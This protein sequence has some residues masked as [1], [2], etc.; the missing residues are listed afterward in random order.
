MHNVVRNTSDNPAWFLLV[1]RDRWGLCQLLAPVPP[2]N[3]Y[4]YKLGH[5]TSTT[6]SSC[7]TWIS[8]HHQVRHADKKMQSSTQGRQWRHSTPYSC[9]EW[10]IW[11]CDVFCLRVELWPQRSGVSGVYRTPLHDV[12][13]RGHLYS[14]FLNIVRYLTN[15]GKCNPASL[16]DQ[17]TSYSTTSSLRKWTST[18]SKIIFDWGTTLQLPLLWRGLWHSITLG[19][20]GRSTL[21]CEHKNLK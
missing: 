2:H 7:Y 12:S 16:D 8:K 6:P 11:D 4:Y 20:T 3:S 14:W 5:P 17:Q 18:S 13:Q 21:R 10:S 9:Q 1:L 19:S 15:I